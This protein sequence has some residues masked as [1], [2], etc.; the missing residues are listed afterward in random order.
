MNNVDNV[1]SPPIG[2]YKR[3]PIYAARLHTLENPALNNFPHL[4]RQVQVL[5]FC[6]GELTWIN[7]DLGDVEFKTVV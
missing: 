7:V 4:Q 3:Q 6:F 1:L 5:K 2:S